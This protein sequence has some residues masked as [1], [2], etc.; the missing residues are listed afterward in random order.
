[1]PFVPWHPVAFPENPM[2]RTVRA[3]IPTMSIHFYISD[4]KITNKVIQ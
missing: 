2:F 3:M 4:V 1:M